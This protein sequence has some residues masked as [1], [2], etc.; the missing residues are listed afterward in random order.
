[1]PFDA[2]TSII[3]AEKAADASVLDAQAE[4]RRLIAE[5][6]NLGRAAV[7][8]E[9]RRAEKE[10]AEMTSRTDVLLAKSN[11]DS[12]EEVRK[13]LEALRSIASG[14]IDLAAKIVAERITKD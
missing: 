11:E 12:A 10:K 7:D 5:A 13:S 14:K 2:V 6:D 8:S 9:K 1:M 4:A 3:E